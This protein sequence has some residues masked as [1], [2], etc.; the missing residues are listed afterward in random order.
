MFRLPALADVVGEDARANDPFAGIK[1][2]RRS[3]A[4]FNVTAVFAAAN[5]FMAAYDL[6]GTHPLPNSLFLGQPVARHQACYRLANDFARR[7]AVELF[8]AGI[9]TGDATVQT[10][11]VDGVHGRVDDGAQMAQLLILPF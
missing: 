7:I 2:G 4:D 11:A 5:R 3:G 6:A 1:Y 10:E 9:P 8:R